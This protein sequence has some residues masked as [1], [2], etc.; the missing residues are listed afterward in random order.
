MREVEANGEL[1]ELARTPLF[2]VLLIS[3]RLAGI[4]LPT[5]R[6]EVYDRVIEHLLETHPA[7]RQI[8]ASAK[9]RPVLRTAEVRRILAAVAFAHQHLADFGPMGARGL[10]NEVKNALQDNDHLALSPAQAAAT[11][12]AFVEIVE[13]QI[14]VVVRQGPGHLAFLHRVLQ[15]QLAAEHGAARLGPDLLR[16]LYT[17]HACDPRWKEVLLGILWRSE[18][19]T[20]ATLVDALAE[21]AAG[22]SIEAQYAREVLAEAVFG[23][24]R[25]TA[26][27]ARRHADAILETAEQHP[28]LPHRARLLTAAMPG[29]DR[30]VVGPLLRRCLDRWVP[31][32]A[33]LSPGDYHHLARAL[34]TGPAEQRIRPI[35]LAGLADEDLG[36]A[37]VAAVAIARRYTAGAHREQVRMALI[38]ALRRPRTAEQAAMA[39]ISLLL[40]WPEDAEVARLTAAARRQP[41]PAVRLV[42]LAAAL[43]VLGPLLDDG[44]EPPDLTGAHT[45]ATDE[46]RAW[47]ERE[48]DSE[49][50][51]RGRWIPYLAET[52]VAATIGRPDLAA[53]WRGRCM[54]IL[55]REHPEPGDRAYAWAVLM[56]GHAAHP[57]VVEFVRAMLI[58][59]LGHAKY[60]G[61]ERIARA[62]P[63]NSAIAA[64]AEKA[65]AVEQQGSLERD[66]HTIAEFDHGPIIRARL[67]KN[68][69]DGSFGY[70]PADALASHWAADPEVTAAL[71]AALDSDP[72]RASM[73]A[74][75]ATRVL[76]PR[77][78]TEKLLRLLGQRAAAGPGFRADIVVYALLEACRTRAE[79]GGALVEKV[80]ATCLAALEEPANWMERDAR[81]TVVGRL[82]QTAASRHGAAL[83]LD[84]AQPPFASLLACF[85]TDPVMLEHVLDRLAQTQ[86]RAPSPIRLHLCSLLRHAVT[87]STYIRTLTRT[88]PAETDELVCSAT[89]AAYHTQLHRDKRRGTAPVGEL[90]AARETIRREALAWGHHPGEHDPAS[91]RRAAWLGASMLD[92]IDLMDDLTDRYG[93]YPKAKVSLG[94]VSGSGD[95]LLL[96]EVADRWPALRSHFGE[97]LPA[98]FNGGSLHPH[99]PELW[100]HLASVAHRSEPLARELSAAVAANQRLLFDHDAVL[101][102]YAQAH[103]GEDDLLDLLVDHI[104]GNGTNLRN[105]A[106]WLLSRPE[107][108]GFEPAQVAARVRARPSQTPWNLTYLT[109]GA[110]EVLAELDPAD[111]QVLAEWDA[112]REERGLGERVSLDVR[113][114]LAV[115]YAAVPTEALLEQFGRDAAAIGSGGLRY[116]APDLAE[117]MTRRIGRDQSAFAAL[118]YV[119]GDEHTGDAAAAQLASLLAAAR[120]LPADTAARLAERLARQGAAQMPDFVFDV[121]SGLDAPVPLLLTDVL[122]LA[123]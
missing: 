7:S 26:G 61:L 24:Y 50:H 15:E 69:D 36:G 8:A 13:G 79:T 46:D 71:T 83:M 18:P 37:Q 9:H 118:A 10:E 20:S 108:V 68:L 27:D 34:D 110:V 89:S 25:I 99:G 123:R 56:R 88:W 70:W 52:A 112:I 44:C 21:R 102:W 39:L 40:G 45:L 93:T 38:A 104:G 74:A 107:S 66:L 87:D 92:E 23:G 75:V 35:L 54:A 55:G 59:D 81:E 47:L 101:A 31:A 32:A 77:E 14:G 82:P 30:P 73:F 48:M 5:R 105:T 95:A 67:L 121:V 98:R 1:R 42:A 51:L 80:A 62:Y 19:G 53:A 122:T 100:G 117:A 63:D 94:Y 86:P 97:D 115:A 6:F 103:R 16:A 65:L 96:D 33:A 84:D 111:P 120:P 91:W 78:G 64:A 49:E 85:G 114:Y 2:L 60:L 43:G 76:G 28:F 106:S 12:L 17:R 41:S 11:A 90:A 29:L 109:S 4:D 58:E 113:T 22:E 116:Y 3:L 57:Q 72:A 119:V